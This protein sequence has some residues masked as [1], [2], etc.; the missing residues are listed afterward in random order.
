MILEFDFAEGLK[1]SDSQMLRCF[2]VAGADG[3][4]VTAV[5]V[6]ADDKVVLSSDVESPEYVR[7]AWQ[8]Y[9][10]ANLVNGEN[11]PA[12]TFFITISEN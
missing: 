5:A 11:L 3:G 8:P 7:Y 12:S 2:E 9:T 4:F 10:S 1:A 6:I